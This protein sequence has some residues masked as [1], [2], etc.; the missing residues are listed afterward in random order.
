[1]AS[2]VSRIVFTAAL[3]L[4]GAAFAAVPTAPASTTVGSLHVQVYGD[5]GRPVVL[6]PGLAGGSWVW[7]ATIDQLRADHVVYA[8][9]L[10]GFDGTPDD[11]GDKPFD[12]AD[13][14]LL[15]LIEQKQLKAPVL[16]GHSLGATLA[17]RFAGEHAD[18]LGGVVAVDGLPVFPGFEAMDATQRAAV[19]G[20]MAQ[21]MAGATPAGFLAQQRQF[22]QAIG[23]I[24]PAMAD[25]YAAMNTRSSQ[26]AVVRYLSEDV[27]GD[28]RPGLKNAHVPILEITG[29]YAPDSAA[30]PRAMTQAQKVAYYR[31]LLAN[32]P[33]LDVVALAPARHYVMLDA[34]A[35]FRQ[36]LAQFLAS[37]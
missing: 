11:A 1:M 13:A 21:S 23:V 30:G 36:T 24:D 27:S 19:A 33:K 31:S 17:L 37:L 7:Q 9:T 26:A 18:L 10:A 12:R 4:S 15:M 14:S 25:K 29:Y 2:H 8:V 6:I 35:A 32:A 22:M 20:R 3:A 5:H 28:W 16:V 34:P